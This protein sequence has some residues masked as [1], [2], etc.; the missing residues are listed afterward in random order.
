[1][2]FLLHL[3]VLLLYY[4]IIILLHYSANILPPALPGRR[5]CLS[6]ARPSTAV[7]TVA[8]SSLEE[9]DNSAAEGGVSNH[10]HQSV[11]V[12]SLDARPTDDA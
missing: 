10:V 2:P 9:A 3:I 5:R 11:N 7:L 12:A 4:Y 8:M 1:M 6:H